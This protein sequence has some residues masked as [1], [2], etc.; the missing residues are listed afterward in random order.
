MR[1]AGQIAELARDRRARRRRDRQRRARPP[2]AAGLDRGDRRDQGRAGRRPAPG[3]HRGR[4]RAASR[5]S[6]RH[7]ARA[8]VAHRHL[9][10]GG[11]VADLGRASSSRLH[12]RPTCASTRWPRWPPRA[13][14]ASSRTAAVEVAL[15]DAARAAGRAARRRRRRQRLLQRQPDVDARRPRRPRRVRA[16]APRRRARRHARAGP[17]RASAS[18]RRSARHARGRGVDV[19]VTVGPLAAHMADRVRRRGARGRRRRRGRRAACPACCSPGDTV[20]V[21]ASRGVGLEVVAERLARRPRSHGRGPHR[22]HGLAAHLHLPEPEVHRVPA[23]AAS[24]ASTSARRAPR[25][26]TR[27]PGTPTMGGIIIFTAISIPFLILQ[28]LRLARRS[29]SSARRW[30]CALLGFADD[31]TKIVKRRSLGLQRADEAR[32]DDR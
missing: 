3:G 24:S 7:S 31:Y 19:L 13:P 30:R 1:G 25:A 21:K 22:G 2:R 9:R 11:D 29:G 5:C 23:R 6:S 15:S 8:D 18:T 26:T 27:R 28:R 14:S 20:L 16:R 4:A 10:P 32:R 17:R 12:A